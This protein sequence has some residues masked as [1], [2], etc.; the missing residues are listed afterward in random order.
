MATRVEHHQRLVVYAEVPTGPGLEEL[1]ERADA[2]RQ[3]DERVGTV[4]H[5]LFALAH[6]VGDDQLVGAV[7]GDLA[8]HQHLGNDTDG[9]AATS[10]G[11]GGQRAHRRD[12]AATPDQGPA[13]VGDRL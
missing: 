4:F 7:V 11:G 9:P 8:P 2:T 5:D 1:L 6:G 3:R 10:A 12:V 13:A